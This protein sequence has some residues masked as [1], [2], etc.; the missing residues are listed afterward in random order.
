MPGVEETAVATAD[1]AV[2][3]AGVVV[4][5]ADKA[6][7]KGTQIQNTSTEKIANGLWRTRWQNATN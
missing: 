3:T 4:V 2:A 1:R 6:I 7:A 5:T